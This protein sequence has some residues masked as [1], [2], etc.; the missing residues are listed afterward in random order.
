MTKKHVW[1]LRVASLWTF[2]VWAVLVRNMILDKSNSLAFRAIHIALA[3]VSIAFAAVTWRISIFMAKEIKNRKKNKVI[4]EGMAL[5][6][7]SK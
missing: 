1:I 7:S 5:P 3:I 6:N 4:G 2:Y